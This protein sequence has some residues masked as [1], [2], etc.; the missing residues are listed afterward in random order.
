MIQTRKMTKGI[1]NNKIGE[2]CKFKESLVPYNNKY[3]RLFV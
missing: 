2:D 3:D 1:E